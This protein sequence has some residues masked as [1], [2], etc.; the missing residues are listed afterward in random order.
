MACLDSNSRFPLIDNKITRC[1]SP[2]INES[3]RK[4]LLEQLEELQMNNSALAKE[5]DQLQTDRKALNNNR[6]QLQ[7]S[8]NSLVKERE[9]REEIQANCDTL[10]EVKNQLE[11]CSQQKGKLHKE[12][13]TIGE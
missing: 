1:Q 11:K 7:A 5:R 8:Y 4:H 6:D 10:T 2:A 12:R 13:S 3:Q 9:K